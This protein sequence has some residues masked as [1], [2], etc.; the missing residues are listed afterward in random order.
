MAILDVAAVPLLRLEED[1][2]LLTAEQ[3]HVVDLKIL[4]IN[5]NKMGVPS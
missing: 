1:L 5:N 2:A 4:A 3:R